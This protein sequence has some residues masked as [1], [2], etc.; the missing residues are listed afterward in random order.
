MIEEDTTEKVVIRKYLRIMI[1]TITLM[2][3]LLFYFGLRQLGVSLDDLKQ[4]SSVPPNY[5]SDMKYCQKD[6][7]CVVFHEPCSSKA[8]NIY[9]FNQRQNHENL[10]RRGLVEC[11]DFTEDLTNPRCENNECAAD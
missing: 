8:I 2:V 1:I 10:K 5:L 6:T 9:N 4:K 7:D 3:G 11:I